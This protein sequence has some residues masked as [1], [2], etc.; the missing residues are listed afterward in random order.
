M[1]MHP[2]IC[3]IGPLTIYSYG[4][5]LALAV[6]ICTILLSRDARRLNIK[7]DCIL[8]LV[9]WVVLSGIL[10]ARAF[11]IFLNLEY[12][13][14]Y[15]EEMIKIH[16]GGLAWQGALILGTVSGIVF[17]RKNGL[18]LWKTLDL[19]G[20]YL[21]LGQ[22]IGRLGC[23][24]NGCCFGREFSKGIFF[25]VHQKFLYPT[26][27]YESTGLLIVFFILKRYQAGNPREGRTF[28]LYLI[29]A[30]LE[31]FFVE[32]FRGDH[33]ITWLGLS[34]FQMISLIIIAAASFVFW[35]LR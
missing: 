25:S 8:D 20:P 12:F 2:V 7:P 18:P 5:M 28:L 33:I 26:Q 16:K 1:A 34:L 3:K 4:L 11:Y 22:A 29:L 31:R 32:F 6:G 9:F 30:S 21:A 14:N 27:L 24:L 13:S 17:M 15:P 35:R 10:G 19:V 23:L